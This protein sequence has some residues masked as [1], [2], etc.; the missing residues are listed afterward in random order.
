MTF[1]STI[2]Q[3]LGINIVANT[4]FNI[5]PLIP[6][7]IISIVGLVIVW[8]GGIKNS[9]ITDYYKWI[10][11]AI[12][13]LI[14]LGY[15]AYTIP[16]N[17]SDLKI[18]DLKDT[19]FL[20]M[21]GITTAI[22]LLTSP[23]VDQTMWQRAFSTDKHSITKMFGLAA[24]IFAIVPASFRLSA[25]MFATQ[26][27]IPNWDISSAIGTNIIGV[28]LA[29]AIIFTLLSTIDSNLCAIEN[30][31]RTEFNQNGRIAMA[32][33]LLLA[34]IVVNTVNLSVTELFL[35]YGTIRTVGALPTILIGFNRFNEQRLFIG[36]ICGIIFGS[37]GYIIATITGFA[38]PAIF[39][40]IALVFP[41]IGYQRK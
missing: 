8:N 12:A 31:A 37:L 18:F 26:G 27:T 10:I 20:L 13:S 39:T 11:I 15:T 34:I 19:Q 6:T 7:I 41:A 38:Y 28:V 25:M 23:Y 17:Y 16:F 2:V 4:W 21:F 36:T 32:V 1:C 3:L 40:I 14:I 24:F 33:T 22:G 30:Y 9:I 5:G 29:I 35:I